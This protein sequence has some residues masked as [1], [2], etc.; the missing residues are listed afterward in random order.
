MKWRYLLSCWFLWL[1]ALWSGPAEDHLASVQ[2]RKDTI[3]LLRQGKL[4]ESKQRLAAT[5]PNGVAASAGDLVLGREWVMISF[6]FHAR[7]ETALARQAAAEA[8]ALATVI[9]R[10]S[11]L[12]SERASFLTNTGLVCERVLRNLAQAKVFYDAALAAQ[13]ASDHTRQLQ[14]HADEKIKRQ[15][16][17][18]G[19][20]S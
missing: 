9:S 18:K 13:P 8:V 17:T 14:R 10:G 11:G 12:S 5:V 7:G 3:A 6:H 19:G 16:T 4:P 15:A 1:P 2:V 20:G